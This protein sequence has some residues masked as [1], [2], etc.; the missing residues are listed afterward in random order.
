VPS[1]LVRGTAGALLVLAFAAGA[2]TASPRFS[3]RVLDYNGDPVPFADLDFFD[4]GSGVK[5][6]PSPPDAPG[7]NDK[8]DFSGVYSLLVTPETY[9]VRYESPTTRTDLASVLLRNIPIAVDTTID[10]TLPQGYPL[11]G[12]VR[13]AQGNPVAGVDLDLTN[14]LTGGRAP[15]PGDNSGASGAYQVVVV[16][17]TYT[18]NFSPPAGSR[19][20]SASVRGVVIGSAVT[21]DVTLA[22]AF[23][24]SG[25]VRDESGGPIAGADLD[26]D[27]VAT[28]LRLFTPDDT[29]APDGRY[30]LTLPSGTFDVIVSPPAG[31]ALASAILRGVAIAADDTL[32]PVTLV[33]GVRVAGSVLGPDGLPLP[34]AKV[35]PFEA[36]SGLRYPAPGGETDGAGAFAFRLPAGDYDLRVAPPGSLALDTLRAGV[37][38]LCC[39]TSL[40][41]AFEPVELVSLTLSLTVEGA[42]TGG[43]LTVW[44][45]PRAGEPLAAAITDA[46]GVARLDVPRDVYDLLVRP[47]PGVLP[48]SVFVEGVALTADTTLAFAFSPPPPPPP[49]PLLALGRPQPNPFRDETRLP[50]FLAPGSPTQLSIHDVAGRRVWAETIPP[51]PGLQIEW[52]WDATD[53][54]GDHVPAGVYLIRLEAGG[55]TASGRV[56]RIE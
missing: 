22:P 29:T 26:L 40:V 7:Q 37:H 36:G 15:T 6:D 32:P 2:A 39:D 33:A 3:G 30:T 19:L 41:F 51:G 44:R 8:T 49:P 52:A 56:V 14:E 43:T 47:V 5:V 25:E 38:S 27:E 46:G 18:V 28:G 35:A 42:P 53:I 1:T 13:D 48:E 16:P 54:H 21:L 17:G 4:A 45:S 12:T 50:L 31:R 23:F 55:R 20:A 34:G 10:V 9:H 11:R 24:V